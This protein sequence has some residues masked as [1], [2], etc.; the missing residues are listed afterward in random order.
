MLSTGTQVGAFRITRHIASGGMGAV[1]EGRHESM[2]FRVA[3]KVL[4][5]DRVQ[6]PTAAAR[7]RN[8]AIAA[9]V[10]EHPHTIKIFESGELRPGLP[11]L[12]MEFLPGKTLAAYLKLL[13]DSGGRA[14]DFATIVDIGSHVACALAV[15]HRR[16]LIHRD[17]KPSNIVLVPLQGSPAWAG[18]PERWHCVLIDWNIAKL[19]PSV[20]PDAPA[21]TTPGQ[22]LGTEEYIAPEQAQDAAST[23][24]RADI[25]SLG[26]VLY[27][28]LTGK[29]PRSAPRRMML[30]EPA[31]TIELG[32]KASPQEIALIGL[33]EQ[34]LVDRPEER[35]TADY[36]EETLRQLWIEAKVP[37]AGTEFSPET[38]SDTGVRAPVSAEQPHRPRSTSIMALVLCN[39]VLLVLVAVLAFRSPSTG[40]PLPPTPVAA[41]EALRPSLIGARSW[42]QIAVE[43]NLQDNLS[44]IWGSS[45]HDIWAVGRKNGTLLHYD[46]RAWTQATGSFK[47]AGLSL[48][49]IW[50]SG[51]QDV[52]AV[53]SKGVILH[54]NGQWEI[55]PSVTDAELLAVSGS[56]AGDILAAGR[57]VIVHYDGREWTPLDVPARYDYHGI[58]FAAPGDAW[59][60]GYQDINSGITLRYAAPKRLQVVSKNELRMRDVWGDKA[61]AVWAVATKAPSLG[62]IL[63]WADNDWT[64][65][66][67][68]PGWLTT[69]WGTG[70]SDV[71][72]TGEGGLMVHYD[73]HGWQ[74]V[75]TGRNGGMFR[76]LFGKRDDLW[77]VGESM[78]ILRFREWEYARVPTPISDNLNDVW[79]Q[80]ERYAWAVGSR[81]QILHYDGKD[82]KGWRRA[83]E[84]SLNGVHGCSVSDVWIVGDEGTSLHFDGQDWQL[85]PTETSERLLGVF[86]QGSTVWAVGSHGVLLRHERGAWQRV[87]S[88]VK[89]DL[90]SVWGSAEGERF[91]VGQN[92][93]V[94][95]I[96]GNVINRVDVG[97]AS[98]CW[99]VWGS[100]PEDV[101][102]STDDGRMLRFNN[103]AFS[104]SP[105]LVAGAL[106]A[107]SGSGSSDVWAAGSGGILLHYDGNEWSKLR[108]G[109]GDSISGIFSERPGSVFLVGE[110]G[111]IWH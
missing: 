103:G 102:I 69:I 48:Y 39:L 38:A 97:V 22:W 106:R 23:D 68:T 29:L 13:H 81:G 64:G 37:S 111:G 79:G 35:P 54:Y 14:P 11:F 94:L 44:G 83:T 56:G 92:G 6:H 20:A 5:P 60:V 19:P 34:M 24:G 93:V 100:G 27:E 95:R 98:D 46:G 59:I 91:A 89:E 109:T 2:G 66:F 61:G 85:V 36:V 88:G 42:R 74:A 21:L 99:R 15:A 90:R 49:A 40:K 107:L 55:A 86:C 77:A 78:T 72:A 26:V 110:R 31:P 105:P 84:R 41:P 4:H 53:G 47:K 108:S 82:W 73:G 8:E 67:L 32:H 17:V 25:Y 70:P 10:V 12:I 16:E 33:V 80:S 9:S 63:R 28:M 7:L 65:T 51:P 104:V 50:G 62:H 57:G 96:S 18:Q 87:E 30:K 75:L 101:W 76:G 71:W 52:W 58:W 43:G 45:P 1:Y 3:I